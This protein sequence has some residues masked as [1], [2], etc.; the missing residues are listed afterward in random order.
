M[1]AGDN[2]AIVP[3]PGRCA[4]ARVDHDIELVAGAKVVHAVLMGLSDIVPDAG[5][6]ISTVVRRLI[7]CQLEFGLVWL[8]FGIKTQSVMPATSMIKSQ[9]LV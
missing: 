9:P 6:A 8:V 5:H 7:T 3:G 2:F 4:A 1:S